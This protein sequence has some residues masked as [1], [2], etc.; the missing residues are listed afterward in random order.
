MSQS[1]QRRERIAAALTSVRTLNASP[2]TRQRLERIK[3]AIVDLAG[4]RSLFPLTD[5]PAPA[6]GYSVLYRLAQD[7]D[8]RLALYLQT[9]LAGNSTPPH[10]HG[11]WAVIASITGNEDNTLYERLDA[12]DQHGVGSVKSSGRLV[13]KP[14]TAIALMPTDIHSISLDDAQPAMHLHVY[15]KP[16][17]K[18]TD[19]V[20]FDLA[21]GTTAHF[22]AHPNIVDARQ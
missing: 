8:E 6:A 1:H 2:M 21:K 9:G 12:G 13:V 11:T 18:M 20:W 3:D 7:P 15:G 5:F 16:I 17:E 14:G 10:N 4:D 19:R 22:E